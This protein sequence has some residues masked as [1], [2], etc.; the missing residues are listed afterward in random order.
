MLT[1]CRR[2]YRSKDNRPNQNYLFV[3]GTSGETSGF[4]SA[5]KLEYEIALY[6]D[7]LIVDFPDVYNN[8]PLKTKAMLEFAE[9]GFQNDESSI[10][11]AVCFSH[12]LSII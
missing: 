5:W 11:L 10:I 4:N 2:I 7:I 6:D 3:I 8:L 12:W 9:V 1:F